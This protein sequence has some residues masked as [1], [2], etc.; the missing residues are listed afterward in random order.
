VPG[1]PA[2]RQRRLAGPGASGLKTRDQE[3]A[4][5]SGAREEGARGRQ[6]VEFPQYF[7]KIG[8]SS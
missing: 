7:M 2:G 3:G 6:E 5:K 8:R 4:G 1:C